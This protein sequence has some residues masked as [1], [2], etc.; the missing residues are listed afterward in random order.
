M[1]TIREK[2]QFTVTSRDE[3][4]SKCKKSGFLDC[5]INAYAEYTEYKGII[6]QPPNFVFID[7]D[8]AN[9]EMDRKKLDL[10]LKRTLKNIED[11]R[12]FPTVLWTGNGYHIYLPINAIVLDQ[13]SIFSK[14]KF[15][16]L[17]S[18]IGKYSNWSVSEVFLKYAEIFFTNGKADPMHNPKYKTCLIRIPGSYNSKLLCNGY[19]K[20]ESL[21]KIVQK[22]KGVR[23]P[24][25]YLLK[26]FRR[27]LFQ[28]ELNERLN[29]SK[30]KVIK[31]KSRYANSSQIEWIERILKT[32]LNDYRK[33]C[34]WKILCPYLIN[35]KK[36]SF[37]ESTYLL[38]NWLN[39]CNNL[40]PT[41]FN[42]IQLIRS[43][44]RNVKT[45]LPPSRTTIRYRYPHFYSM[46]NTKG[47]FD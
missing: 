40:Q 29:L 45:F 10:R 36:L 7:L 17:F 5:R 37:E 47:I 4:F 14:E 42:H 35:I 25:Q 21:V 44:L 18:S 24:V 11:Y 1:M 3:V 39:N 20:E 12:G 22:W 30:R 41:V 27:W 23:I 16:S 38:E 34:L 6:R 31:N 2:Y 8:L 15:P 46:L 28:E 9:F 26:N 33:L 13:E 19:S 32:S 43:N